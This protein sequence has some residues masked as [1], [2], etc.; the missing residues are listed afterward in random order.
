MSSS[1]IRRFPRV[2]KKPPPG[3][4]IAGRLGIDWGSV[5]RLTEFLNGIKMTC[6]AHPHK[7][8][9]AD[10]HSLIEHAAKEHDCLVFEFSA[11][12]KNVFTVG[13]T[14]RQQCDWTCSHLTAI[15]KCFSAP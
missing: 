15:A 5:H 7:A 11:L 6:T 13:S 1:P 9:S 10:P 3:S 2:L 8:V 12:I 4:E 14:I